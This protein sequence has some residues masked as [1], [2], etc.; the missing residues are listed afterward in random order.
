MK[1]GAIIMRTTGVPDD[2]PAPLPGETPWYSGEQRPVQ[3]GLYKRLSVAGPVMYS[4][5]DGENWL[6]MHRSPTV[7]VRFGSQDISLCQTLPWCGLMAPPPQ[8]YGPLPSDAS[9]SEGGEPC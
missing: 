3:I 4:F 1:P 2:A 5:F 7:A 9:D 8:G 6:W